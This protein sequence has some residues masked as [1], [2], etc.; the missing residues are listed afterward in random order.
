M[1]T[2]DIVNHETAL[3]ITV[4]VLYRRNSDWFKSH[5]VIYIHCILQILFDNADNVSSS[6]VKTTCSV[7]RSILI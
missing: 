6:V 4:G 3:S 1:K 7:L 2:F 5:L